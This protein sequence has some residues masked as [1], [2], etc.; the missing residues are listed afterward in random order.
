MSFGL[1][2]R[3][4]LRLR[5]AAGMKQRPG[6]RKLAAARAA[7][8]QNLPCS[9]SPCLLPRLRTGLLR[10]LAGPA[11]GFLCV[12]WKPLPPRLATQGLETATLLLSTML[13]SRWA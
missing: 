2:W 13:A 4:R 6:G 10:R 12:C 7:G 9:C 8:R 11:A 1:I 3:V 5:R